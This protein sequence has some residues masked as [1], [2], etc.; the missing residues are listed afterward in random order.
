MNKSIATSA[1]AFVM[2]RVEYLG[3]PGRTPIIFLQ[4]A[5]LTND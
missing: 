4:C 2:L 3:T 5:Q 1:L